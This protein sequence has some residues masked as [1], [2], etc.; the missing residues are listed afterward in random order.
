V[1]SRFSREHGPPP[2]PEQRDALLDDLHRH[3]DDQ[4]ET[5]RARARSLAS[6]CLAGCYWCCH[7]LVLVD[8]PDALLVARRLISSRASTPALRCAL[9]ADAARAGCQTPD[10]YFG[11]ARGCVFLDRSAPT[12][13]CSIYDVRPI[14]CGIWFIH[15]VPNGAGCAPG[16][17]FREQLNVTIP[18]LEEADLR[19]RTRWARRFFP[20]DEARPVWVPLALGVLAAVD[21]LVDGRSALAAWRPRLD[22]ATRRS[23]SLVDE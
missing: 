4:V 22:E 20:G 17:D 12:A 14:D 5:Y 9:E 10:E 21:F 16:A 3:H 1:R 15:D 6:P 19:F 18:S 8:L 11:S 7:R 2:T 13:A 23:Y